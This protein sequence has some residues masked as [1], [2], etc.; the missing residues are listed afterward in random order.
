[1]IITTNTINRATRRE[2]VPHSSWRKP[3][4]KGSII[5]VGEQDADG[6]KLLLEDVQQIQ[7][8]QQQVNG[9]GPRFQQLQASLEEEREGIL[10]SHTRSLRSLSFSRKQ[11]SQPAHAQVPS[12]VRRAPMRSLLTLA[13]QVGEQVAAEVKSLGDMVRN[14]QLTIEKKCRDHWKDLTKSRRD[15][16]A[17]FHIQHA[18]NVAKE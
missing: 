13:R 17:S 11:L 8:H 2:L 9:I 1:M 6:D 14:H 18:I 10:E 3:A 12:S 7:Q 16:H 4:A 15:S 5:S